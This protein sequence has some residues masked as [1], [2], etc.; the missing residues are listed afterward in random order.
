MM[1]GK[2]VVIDPGTYTYT[3]YPEWRNTFSSTAFHNTVYIENVEQNDISSE[4][5]FMAP[6]VNSLVTRFEEDEKAVYFTGETHYR[7][8]AI[9]HNRE[10]VLSKIDSQLEVRDHVKGAGRATM[11]ICLAPKA[12]KFTFE[13]DR[14]VFSRERGSFSKDYGQKELT[15]RLVAGVGSGSGVVRIKGRR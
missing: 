13:V 9:V 15:N 12:E 1:N 5:F 2:D 10:I 6:G 4:L 8:R 14:G 11:N 7:R 3:P